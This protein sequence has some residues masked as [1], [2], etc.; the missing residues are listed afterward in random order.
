MYVM[1]ACG[2]IS[3]IVKIYNVSLYNNIVL[4]N[5]SFHYQVD[6]TCLH[7][8]PLTGLDSLLEALLS[9]LNREVIEHSKNSHEYFLFFYRYSKMVRVG[10]TIYSTS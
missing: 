6:I 10:Y 7:L 1:C 5:N 8:Q 4:T 9:L 3:M 2:C